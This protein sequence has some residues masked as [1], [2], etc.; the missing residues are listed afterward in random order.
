MAKLQKTMV[1]YR[2]G[3]NSK[4][5]KAC[6]IST[7]KRSQNPVPVTLHHV[8]TPTT[9]LLCLCYL[10]RCEPRRCGAVSCL[11]LFPSAQQRACITVNVENVCVTDYVDECVGEWNQVVNKQ[12]FMF[13]IVS[14]SSY[15][16]GHRNHFL[17]I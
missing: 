16:S 5:T 14:L 8:A 6:A 4:T 2:P 9:A 13:P 1:K 12:Q 17:L 7:C 11:L 10:P 3:F 15:F